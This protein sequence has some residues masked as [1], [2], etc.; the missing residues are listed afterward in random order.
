MYVYSNNQAKGN[1][2]KVAIMRMICNVRE[3]DKRNYRE[4][5]QSHYNYCSNFPDRNLPSAHSKL[6]LTI[7]CTKS[8]SC[9]FSFWNFRTRKERVCNIC[10]AEG[11]FTERKY[12]RRSV[13]ESYSD[14]TYLLRRI[15]QQ[16]LS[17]P[18]L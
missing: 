11:L 15:L 1:L 10:A 2:E 17:P 14:I 4:W 13:R 18:K 7:F 16:S 9:K 8:G 6:K 5:I 3:R 12:R